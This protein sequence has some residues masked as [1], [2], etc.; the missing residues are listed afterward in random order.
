[1]K[2]PRAIIRSACG[3]SSATCFPIRRGSQPASAMLPL[4]SH[5]LLVIR[6]AGH[7]LWHV[8]GLVLTPHNSGA[9]EETGLLSCV[10]AQ[11]PCVCPERVL[12][13]RR[14]FCMKTKLYKVGRRQGT[15]TAWVERS[16][17]GGNLA[18][19]I[20]SELCRTSAHSCGGTCVESLSSTSSTTLMVTDGCS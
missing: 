17:S 2:L 16:G 3:K 5:C 20:T 10:S 12:A 11:L 9:E 4:R 15:R 8:P 13:K 18:G 7:P 14:V 1:M 19:C 6:S